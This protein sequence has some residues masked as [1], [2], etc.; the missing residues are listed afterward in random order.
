MSPRQPTPRPA[1]AGATT[2]YDSTG[3]HGHGLF[4]TG[5]PV[6][7]WTVSTALPVRYQVRSTPGV[8]DP[9]N[10]AIAEAGVPARPGRRRRLLVVEARVH[11]LYGERIARYCEAQ[12]IDHRLCVIPAHEQVK[13]MDSVFRVTRAMEE[14]GLA[15]RGEPVIAIGGGVLTDVVGLACSLYRRSTPFVRVPTTLIGLVDAGVGAKTGVNFDQHKN[16]LGTYHPAVETL[17]DPAFLATLEHRHIGN[18]MAEILKVALIKDRAL[19]E[20]LDRHGPQL[21]A[22]RF[23]HPA[24]AEVVGRAVGGMLSELQ[25][26]LWEHEL[27]RSMDYGH[28]FSPTLEMRALPELLHGEAVCVDM[29]LT[30]VLAGQRGL[31][32]PVECARILGLMARLGLPLWHRLLQPELLHDALADTIRHRDGR[33]RLPLPIG[34]GAGVFV[35][36]LTPHEL[37]RAS[38]ELHAAARALTVS[39]ESRRAPAQARA[40]AA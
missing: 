32:S 20:L 22:E 6:T 30:T 34:I 4:T 13:T 35:D 11:E 14:F 33:Q 21:R 5:T 39:Q 12:R 3:G 38:S 7:G 9:A 36:D 29:A 18:G 28:S 31:V 27:E 37:S 8:L 24:A 15:R 25:P 23:Q 16:R 10:P 1:G 2:R 26:N 40:E 19:F 17:L